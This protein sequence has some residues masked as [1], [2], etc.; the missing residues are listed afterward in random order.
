MSVCACMGPAGNCPCIRRQ[1]GEKIEITETYIAPTLFALLSDEDKMT[2]NN[3]KWKALG[4]SLRQS[5]K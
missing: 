3:L 4:L 5:T 2:I 1:R